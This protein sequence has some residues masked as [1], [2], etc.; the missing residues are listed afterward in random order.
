MTGHADARRPL[1]EVRLEVAATLSAH[2]AE[3]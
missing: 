2:M 3:C 1:P